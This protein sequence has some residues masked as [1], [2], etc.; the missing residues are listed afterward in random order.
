MDRPRRPCRTRRRWSWW[1]QAT[2][3][4]SSSGT[5]T[6]SHSP[7]RLTT[8][9]TRLESNSVLGPIFTLNR[10]PGDVE[11]LH[12]LAH[13]RHRVAVRRPGVGRGTGRRSA[14]SW[15]S[16]ILVA[17]DRR[18]SEPTMS[19]SPS[20]VSAAT[21]PAGARTA[22]AT[23]RP[24]TD[25][26][27]VAAARVLGLALRAARRA[28]RARARAS[29]ATGSA[30]GAGRG[31]VLL[32][33]DGAVA[34]AAGRGSGVGLG[35][36]AGSGAG[37]GG[38]QVPRRRS[39]AAASACGRGP[40]R[41]GRRARWTGARPRRRACARPRRLRPR[42][43]CSGPRRARAGAGRVEHLPIPGV[44]AGKCFWRAVRVRSW[45]VEGPARAAAGYRVVL[46]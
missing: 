46:R 34:R 4:L 7:R 16:K 44:E 31:L 6:A 45:A 26:P 39:P 40:R 18:S 41:A 17:E 38:Q 12:R 13:A 8:E 28:C 1:I 2:S 20:P 14:S 10:P 3:P 29:P 35:T 30:S 5:S 36:G 27:P 15:G 11:Q 9:R 25:A 23:A 32:R 24:A 21:M 42:R 43:R 33:A 37:R 19:S 22:S